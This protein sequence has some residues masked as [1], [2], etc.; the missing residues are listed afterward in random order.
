MPLRPKLARLCRRIHRRSLSRPSRLVVLWEF[1]YGVVTLISR[2][3][4]VSLVDKMP[5]LYVLGVRD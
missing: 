1:V 2:R 5:A 4:Y 3:L